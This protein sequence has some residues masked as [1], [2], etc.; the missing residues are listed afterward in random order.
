M[1]TYALS[2]VAPT[3]DGSGFN[4][5]GVYGRPL[6]SFEF[7][8]EEEAEGAHKA[9]QPVLATTKLITTHRQSGG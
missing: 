2:K 5:I 4:I 9:M 3:I 7:E 8:T 1:D 6:V